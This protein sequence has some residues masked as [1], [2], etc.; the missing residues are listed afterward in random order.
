M[1][2]NRL[3]LVENLMQIMDFTS[4]FHVQELLVTYISR[5]WSWLF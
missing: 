1:F 5:A 3:E 2:E 4:I